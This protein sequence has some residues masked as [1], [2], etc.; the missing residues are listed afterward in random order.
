MITAKNLV[1]K[2]KFVIDGCRWQAKKKRMM[3]NDIL[4]FTQRAKKKLRKINSF[5]EILE[6]ET[7][8]EFLIGAA[9]LSKKSINHFSSTDLLS[10]L[11]KVI[12]FD[13]LNELNYLNELE[14][15]Y[16][17][18]SGDSVGGKMR[19][20]I[21]H[22]GNDLLIEYITTYLNEHN[23][24]YK[25][26]VNK[27]NNVQSIETDLASVIF[28]KKPKFINKSIDFIVLKKEQ[29]KDYDIENPSSYIAA[30]ELKSGIDP[31]GADEHWKTATTA[32]SRIRNTFNDINK[33]IPL[34]FIGGAISKHMANEIIEAIEN[35]DLKLAANL[36]IKSQMD[37]L[38]RDMFKGLFTD[39]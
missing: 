14:R 32:L 2:E 20:L 4:K 23:V 10:F 25:L 37:F 24:D 33:E 21:G 30:G 5:Y 38:I 17:L 15:Y 34:Y 1:T 12:D 27:N 13:R 3:A 31:A 39:K 35:N 11:A 26:I 36:N 7:M 6:S 8:T 22:K 28:N 16:L 9:M 29:N 18:T 19:N